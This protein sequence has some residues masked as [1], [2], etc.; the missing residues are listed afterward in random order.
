MDPWAQSAEA[1]L[2]ETVDRRNTKISLLFPVSCQSVYQ[3]NS[4]LV[5]VSA[6]RNLYFSFLP[7][8]RLS[9]EP[10]PAEIPVSSFNFPAS[11]PST[12]TEKSLFSVSCHL[13]S[14][15]L[16]SLLLCPANRCSNQSLPLP[17][18]AVYCQFPAGRAPRVG[19]CRRPL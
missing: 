14:A 10:L 1:R 12:S 11:P 4:L 16:P 7:V 15:V 2:T 13:P 3:K 5:E 9:V 6:C 8:Y 18:A 17:V 19:I